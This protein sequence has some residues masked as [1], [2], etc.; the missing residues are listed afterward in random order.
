MM[1]EQEHPESFITADEIRRLSIA[2]PSR[3]RQ[4][5]AALEPTLGNLKVA[6]R[7]ITRSN[8]SIRF[9]VDSLESLVASTSETDLSELFR[10]ACIW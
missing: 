3:L 9:M 6:Y 8:G 2:A 7:A 10:Y 4:E 5:M 1:E